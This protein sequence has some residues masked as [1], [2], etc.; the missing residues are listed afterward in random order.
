MALPD[1]SEAVAEARAVIATC[2]P[3][4]AGHERPGMSSADIARLEAHVAPDH[5]ADEVLEFLAGPRPLVIDGF[6]DL[7]FMCDSYG[8][9][10]H[11]SYFWVPV[12][13]SEESY[14][15]VTQ[16]APIARCPVAVWDTKGL[17]VCAPFPSWRTLVLSFSESLRTWHRLG[18]GRPDHH[19]ARWWQFLV[20]PPWPE[21]EDAPR[22]DER[23][24]PILAI[25]AAEDGSPMWPG[26]PLP[27]VSSVLIDGQFEAHEEWLDLLRWDISG[28]TPPRQAERR[29]DRDER[30]AAEARARDLGAAPD[31]KVD[32]VRDA[33][34]GTTP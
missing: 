34:R 32:R 30:R 9:F 2:A 16:P 14:L 19:F 3:S 11:L 24:S 31:T 13:G 26:S 23:R 4:L 29:R 33:R 10:D 1:M 12:G 7:D 18:L 17:M 20:D 21:P 28:V 27:W 22:W 5:L 25:I 15:A 6:W 8:S